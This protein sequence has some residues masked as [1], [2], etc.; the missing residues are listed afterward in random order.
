M[1]D[2]GCF[3]A[4]TSGWKRREFLRAGLTTLASVSLSGF[5][6]QSNL[7]PPRPNEATGGM[8][9]LTRDADFKTVGRGKPPPSELPEARRRE[10]GLAPETWQLEVVA[11]PNSD[12]KLESP[13]SKARGTALTWDGLMKLADRHAVRFLHVMAC[14]NMSGP[15]GLGL[16]EG[17]PLAEIIRLAQPTANARRVF[18]HGYHHDDPQQLF[19]SSLTIDRALEAPPGEWPV[20]LC[21]KLNGQWLTPKRGG[22]VRMLVPGLY[23]NKSV[24]W[25]QR[26]LITNDPRLN[27]TYAEWNNDT[28]SPLKT[29]AF[30]RQVPERVRA[31]QPVPVAGVAQVGMSGLRQ[32]QYF[33]QR[34]DEPWL[35][36]DPFF[37]RAAWRDAKILPPPRHWGGGLTEGK[38]PP[39]VLGFN[40][41]TAKPQQ[42]PIRDSV[43]QWRATLSGL[44]PGRYDLRCRTLDA[45]GA[46]QPMPRP[47][48]KAGRNLIQSASFVVEA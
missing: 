41:R 21:Y 12:S 7:R 45:N 27:D 35:S 39:G 44:A 8:E 32:V 31:R 47:L 25:L 20:I 18:Y 3:R 6:A 43:V 15:L 1:Q 29:C 40:A 9:Y 11:A 28:E 13:L 5:G 38:L 33:L 36:D 2:A 48:P 26:I 16:W 23:A 46:A 22:P 30:F 34:K 37:T 14:T 42:W 4:V 17:V 10:V 24:K 19:Q